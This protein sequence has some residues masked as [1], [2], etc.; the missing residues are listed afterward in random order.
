[1]SQRLSY[2]KLPLSYGA[3]T[4]AHRLGVGGMAET[5][6][7]IKRAEAGFEQRVCLKRILSSFENDAAFEKMFLDEARLSAKLRHPNIA[8][9]LDFGDVDGSLYLTLELIEGTDLRGLLGH[10]FSELTTGLVSYIAFELATALE[11]AHQQ[12]VVHRDV[13]PSNVLVSNS[14]EIKL[15]DFGIARA[16]SKL[17]RSDSIKGKVQYMAPEYARTGDYFPTADLFSLGVVLYECVCGRRPFDGET[18]PATL[19]NSARGEFL[20]VT[21]LVPTANPALAGIIETLIDSDPKERFQDATELIRALE[22]IEAPPTAPKILAR[23]VTPLTPQASS[24]PPKTELQTN[25]LAP[26]TPKVRSSSPQAKTRTRVKADGP[27]DVAL[28]TP[29]TPIGE[30]EQRLDPPSQLRPS[31]RPMGTQ[32]DSAKQ[33]SGDVKMLA[34]GAGIGVIIAAVAGLLFIL[35]S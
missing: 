1:M 30:P 10:C 9:V 7:A 19:R 33:Q 32:T 25:G 14:G 21:S 12:G 15:A 23:L 8:Q 27:T 26:V 18:A 5:F 6:I 3:Y 16:V 24:P 22:N 2:A 29:Q 31:H 11:F 17:T 20:K 34:I 4:L 13:S 35:L 28:M